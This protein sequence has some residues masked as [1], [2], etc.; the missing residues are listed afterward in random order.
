MNIGLLVLIIEVNVS[1][2]ERISVSDNYIDYLLLYTQ[3]L[4]ITQLE[5]AYCIFI[6]RNNLK[7]TFR[8][9]LRA[10]NTIIITESVFYV[11][12]S[13]KIYKKKKK[14]TYGF[15]FIVILQ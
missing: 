5:Y 12:F 13:I 7:V 14:K 15:N 11:P 2:S 9:R 10:E 4:Y 8:N 3:I 6:K 1:L